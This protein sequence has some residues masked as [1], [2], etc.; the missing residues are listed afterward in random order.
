MCAFRVSYQKEL[1]EKK[2]P[3]GSQF[4]KYNLITQKLGDYKKR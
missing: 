2:N 1:T 3:A 4:D